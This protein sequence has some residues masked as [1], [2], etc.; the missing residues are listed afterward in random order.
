VIPYTLII[1]PA[2][3]ARWRKK[4]LCRFALAAMLPF[5][6]LFP[7][8]AVAKRL[9]SPAVFWILVG[10]A[11]AVRQCLAVLA[12]TCVMVFINNSGEKQKQALPAAYVLF[13]R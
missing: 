8:S 10:A 1:F 7:L 13:S 12:F 9:C 3:N 2:A 5:H 4:Q 11:A 6:T